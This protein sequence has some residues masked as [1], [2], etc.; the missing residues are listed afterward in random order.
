MV[1]ATRN[2]RA[3]RR[4]RV[5]RGALSIAFTPVAPFASQVAV[6]ASATTVDVSP[7]L[8]TGPTGGVVVLTARVYDET[9]TSM[10]AR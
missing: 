7:E 6:A 1:R 9:G 2:Q 8:G 5:A 3:D 4:C 10:R